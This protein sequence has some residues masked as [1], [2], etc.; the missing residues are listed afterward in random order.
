MADD[1][2]MK[3]FVPKICSTKVFFL[4][5]L[6]DDF[7]MKN[8]VP[9]T[10]NTKVFF[11]LKM[12]DDFCMKNFFPEICSTMVFFLSVY[13]CL[14]QVLTDYRRPHLVRKISMKFLRNLIGG[15]GNQTKS[16][17]EKLYTQWATFRAKIY[18]YMESLS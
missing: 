10:C 4:L 14:T 15:Q 2:C 16:Q 9:E 7:Y 17:P 6:A 11:V 18:K 12:A 8:C 5:K 13:I 1:F 3:N